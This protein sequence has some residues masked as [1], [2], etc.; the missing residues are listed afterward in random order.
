MGKHT[1]K[2]SAEGWM[3]E[4]KNERDFI[5]AISGD[6]KGGEGIKSSKYGIER[7]KSK[8]TRN[9]YTSQEPV[10]TCDHPHK[11]RKRKNNTQ[12]YFSFVKIR[13]SLQSSKSG[14]KRKKRK[15]HRRKNGSLATQHL[16]V[17]IAVHRREGGRGKQEEM[18]GRRAGEPLYVNVKLIQCHFYSRL[19]TWG[20]VGP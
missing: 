1:G 16:A 17:E 2:D 4:G 18:G 10:S 14:P 19:K 9:K 3:D 20:F 7:E 8:G 6:R 13:P 15:K 12:F 11:R 5:D